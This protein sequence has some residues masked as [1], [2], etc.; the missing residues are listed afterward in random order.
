MIIYHTKIL[1]FLFP[2]FRIQN[3]GRSLVF[4]AD[5]GG[6]EN[7]TLMSTVEYHRQLIL[8][9]WVRWSEV[10]EW[11]MFLPVLAFGVGSIY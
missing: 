9:I 6:L 8:A 10:T 7:T 11:E 2:F 1:L 3:E 4:P 5:C